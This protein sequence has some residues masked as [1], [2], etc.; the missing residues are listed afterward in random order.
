MKKN[1]IRRPPKRR[2]TT[3]AE[4]KA[5]RSPV[6]E[7]TPEEQGAVFAEMAR[8]EAA[9]ARMAPEDRAEYDRILALE[10]GTASPEEDARA[11]ELLVRYVALAG[12]DE[13]R[14]R[15]AAFRAN[16]RRA[17]RQII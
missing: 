3:K 2:K 6:I 8:E 14:E 16:A 11:D 9:L 7:L 13:I 5:R 17:K 12:D 4:I 10:P 1:R 15:V